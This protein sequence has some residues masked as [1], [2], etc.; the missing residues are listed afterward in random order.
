MSKPD[1]DSTW[2]S[3]W[4][5]QKITM[6]ASQMHFSAEYR[7]CGVETAEVS[8]VLYAVPQVGAD[9]SSSTAVKFGG[10]TKSKKKGPLQTQT[11]T[12]SGNQNAV[13]DILSGGAS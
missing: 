6:S 5:P 11:V 8:V 9:Q 12:V 10:S 1:H 13:C 3:A 7:R 2:L 4:L